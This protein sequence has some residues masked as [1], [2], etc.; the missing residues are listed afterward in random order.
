ME[1]LLEAHHA[2]LSRVALAYARTP[3][4]RQ[5]LLQEIAIALVRAWP[6]FRGDCSERTFVFRVAHNQGFT[7]ATRHR[8]R[9]ARAG[10][11]DAVIETIAD[12][13][14]SPEERAAAAEESARLWAAIRD[15]PVAHRAVLVLALED[16]AHAEIASVL[17]ITPNHVA[18][19][20]GRAREALRHALE[21]ERGGTR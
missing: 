12:D 1:R 18:V 17:G 15:L 20:L 9:S 7:F 10:G 16:L 6:S 5:D 4:D 11:G 13:A 3:A 2:G 8:A 19:R 14:A 21:K